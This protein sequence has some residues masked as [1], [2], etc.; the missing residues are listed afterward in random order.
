MSMRFAA[1]ACDYDG[2][3]ASH[4]RLGP[5]ALAALARAGQAGLR[6]ILVTGR[7]F[8]E[9]LRVCGR[10]DIFD[11]VVAENG[12]VVYFPR[13]GTLHDDAPTPPLRLLA[14]LDRR[15][16]VYE[17][18]RVV[19]GTARSDAARVAEALAAAAVSLE[20]VPNR[21]RLMLLPHGISKGSGV[22]RVIRDLGLSPHDVLALG[23]AEND[24][25]LFAAC[26]FAACPASAVTAVRERA[27]WVF[28]G[29][30]GS[31]VAA[32]IV[33]PILEGTLAV[34]GAPRHRVELGW[35]AGTGERVSVPSRGTSLLIHGDPASGKS[36]L[37]GV[38]LEQLHDRRYAIL[39]IDPEGDYAVLAQLPG[40]TWA[41]VEDP[42]AM[43][44]AVDTLE[45]DPTGCVIA[46]LSSRRHAEKVRL[47]EAGLDLAGRLRERLGR[48]HW[49]VLDEAHY[50]LH[51]T[52]IDPRTIGLSRKG[53]C[54]VTYK[55]SWLRPSIV[56]GIDTL[57]L[58]RTSAPEELAWLDHVLEGPREACERVVATLPGLPTGA[59][60][61]IPPE[62]AA[63]AVT[64][65]PAQ[66]RTQH[67]RHRRKYADSR[68]AAPERFFFRRPDGTVVGA[69][70]SLGAFAAALPSAPDE[71]LAHHA[72]HGD[73]S[74]W[75]R[76]VF[77][78]R[79]LGRQLR[80]LEARWGRGEVR[81]LRAALQGLIALR[82]GTEE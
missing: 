45:R 7:T 78:D 46:D 9:L 38:L 3:L 28:P 39:V 64:F 51:P 44:A 15:G 43:Q 74:R 36:W 77:S 10:L 70:E 48:P 24:L 58:A 67:V 62:G 34:G 57:V 42:L 72:R 60:V 20:V 56:A 6:L 31:A 59:F 35:A 66:R 22:R 73:Y 63:G 52:G 4:D 65:T 71:V 40:V 75:V 53:F 2:T 61:L 25:D 17:L 37:A 30:D 18:G 81:D 1:L 50:S 23:D 13:A 26:G 41:K 32:A 12:A 19:V 68:V 33:G 14:E 21:G 82:Y 16:I 5:E 49:I 11:G 8:F 29:E 47:I 55:P 54:L 76:D 27:D 80:K 69:A 79:L